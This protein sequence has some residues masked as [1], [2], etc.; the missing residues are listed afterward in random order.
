M[1]PILAI[2]RRNKAT[3]FVPP[4]SDMADSNAT[5]IAT[6]LAAAINVQA[7]KTVFVNDKIFLPEEFVEHDLALDI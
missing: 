4:F 5:D 7:T 1:L 6:G 3:L 2:Q